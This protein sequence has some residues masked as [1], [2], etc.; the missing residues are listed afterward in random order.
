VLRIDRTVDSPSEV[1]L[2][3]AGDLRPDDL[4][5]LRRVLE[6]TTRSTERIIIDLGAMTLACREAVAFLGS[7]EATGVALSNCPPYLREWIT[8]EM[9]A[10]AR[11]EK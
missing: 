2:R 5:E 7:C 3:L 8:S 10:A 6:E 1:V 11:T 9:R 4:P